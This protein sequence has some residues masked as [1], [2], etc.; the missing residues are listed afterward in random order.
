MGDRPPLVVETHVSVLLFV[1]DKV[2]KF[3]KAVRLPFVDFTTSRA[4]RRACL[5]EVT[6][7][8]RLSPDVYLG[9]ADLVLPA[10]GAGT[11]KKA[12][13]GSEDTDAA[14]VV[15]D[16][17]VIMRRLPA[18][19]SLETLV[20]SGNR[21]MR[22]S[23]IQLAKLLA[24]FHS[25]AARGPKID[26]AARPQAM[27]ATWGRCLETLASYGG[28]LVDSA[29]LD[30]IGALALE[31]IQGRG[32]LFER[33]IADGRVCDGHGDLLAGDVFFL[34]DGPRV[35]DAIDFDPTLRFVD[36]AA[37]VAFLVMDLE[38]LGAGKEA[39]GFL[40]AYQQE[41]E[42]VFPPTLLHHYI[43]QRATVRAEVAC[44]AT[45]GPSARGSGS[46]ANELLELAHRHLRR[47]RVVMTVVHGLPGTGKSTVSVALAGRLGWPVV[48]S[49]DLRRQLVAPG[50][51]GPLTEGA[52]PGAYADR[53]TRQVYHSLLH[54]AEAALALGQPVILDATFTD[55]WAREAAAAVARKTHSRL[56]VVSCHLPEA[57]AAHRMRAR[58]ALGNDVSGADESVARR[59]IR[60]GGGKPWPGA[61]DVDT[62]SPISETVER[63]VD[64]IGLSGSL[65]S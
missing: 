28:R 53:V 4:R 9:V 3:K 63:I 32:K 25:G 10:T 44:L 59:L 52:V 7:N 42:D 18:D 36:V 55:S 15:I 5:E 17:A 2:L 45:E 13:A 27:T 8:K 23:L 54:E 26:E 37:D 41:A 58:M 50:L 22:S 56:T 20:T 39:D 49:D 29:I 16:H 60:E 64:T 11:S 51:Q 33:R 19:R 65:N 34:E 48:R 21:E 61:L 24:R 43:A 14:S 30:K 35:L 38:R 6:A 40:A 46:D 1:G 62:R 12:T 47:G 57:V 31:Y